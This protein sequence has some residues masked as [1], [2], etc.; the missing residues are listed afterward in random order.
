MKKFALA[1][2]L[3]AS[4]GLAQAEG[5]NQNNVYIG[6]GLGKNSLSGFDDAMGFQFF[7]GYKL[8]NVKLGEL[9]SAVEV[10]Y[11]SSGD[12][13]FEVCIPTFL[14]P[15]CETGKTDATGLWATYV[16]RYDF[17]PAAYGLGRI[18]LDFGDDDGM[19]F[20]VGAGYKI[21]RQMDI[22]GE[23]V[24]RENIDSLQANL[25]YYMK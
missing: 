2:V 5:F 11:M 3:L 13:E 15:I 19:M 14:G 4:A 21:N 6:G 9:K 10:G 22:R 7:G 23:Y 20:G 1:M 24:S 17:S 8:D 12:F 18:G 25:V 16:A